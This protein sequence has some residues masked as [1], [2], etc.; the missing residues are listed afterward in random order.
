[1]AIVAADLKFLSSERMVDALSPAAGSS[2]GGGFAAGPVL[3]D[4]V[5]GNVFPPAGPADLVA[6]RRRVRLVYP[7]VLSNENSRALAG[8]VAVYRRA[9]SSSVDLL[10]LSSS[11]LGAILTAGIPIGP[12][13]FDSRN[14]FWAAR[15]LDNFLTPLSN[16]AGGGS[17][18]SFTAPLDGTGGNSVTAGGGVIPVDIVVGDKVMAVSGAVGASWRTVVSIT[19]GQ[20]VF[21]GGG[22]A[23]VAGGASVVI[24]R[25]SRTPVAPISAPATLTAGVSGGA[26]TVTVST[27]Q[28]ET[29]LW[30]L[31]A[32]TLTP[33][34]IEILTVSPSFP[35]LDGT[36][37]GNRGGRAPAFG[38]G[39][40]VLVDDP[41]NG[42]APE[43]RVVQRVNYQTGEITFT[44][45]LTNSYSTGSIIS[46]LVDCGDWQAEVS[47]P[48]FSQQA[49]TRAWADVASGPTITPRYTGVI[50]MN[51]AGGID[52]RW[53]IVFTSS[54]AFNLISE[55]LGQIAS[56]NTLS[57]FVPLNPLTSQPLMT[58][59]ASGWGGGWLPG[60]VVRF[61][62]RG[63]HSGVFYVQNISPGA[64]GAD[65]GE[66][67]MRCDA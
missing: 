2:S 44:T 8:G 42:T 18:V 22:L 53:A 1:M 34:V 58:L 35:A 25:Y 67:I 46:T 47:L 57:N 37:P 60:N 55:R 59:A 27:A 20:L 13:S 30:P 31:G 14:A 9:A 54:T 4:G 52:D 39:F 28:L 7:A 5:V 33:G 15:A 64:S 63:A 38:V 10:A 56:G 12:I 11:S 21:G 43:V 61:N 19:G 26:S 29:R 41:T 36:L 49:W 40:K 23:G 16:G 6:G 32:T 17:A 3:Q 65:E 24:T 50:G 62:T 66:L 51:N 45:P 48:P